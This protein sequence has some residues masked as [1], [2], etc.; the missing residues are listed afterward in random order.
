MARTDSFPAKRANC[1]QFPYDSHIRWQQLPTP[2]GSRDGV[3]GGYLLVLNSPKS[4]ASRRSKRGAVGAGHVTSVQP[5]WR[6]SPLGPHRLSRLATWG[7]NHGA[8]RH[9][10]YIRETLGGH[11]IVFWVLVVEWTAPLWPWMQ[12]AGDCVFY[13]FILTMGGTRNWQRKTL[14]TLSTDVVL[15]CIPRSW[16]GIFNIIFIGVFC[17][18]ILYCKWTRIR[19]E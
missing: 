10:R 14:R 12:S 9:R 11:M 15:I 7:W 1:T 8:A 2:W 6:I 3:S 19:L 5:H 16:I 18:C 13:V 4:Q 17:N